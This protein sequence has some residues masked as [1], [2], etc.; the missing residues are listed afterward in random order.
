[1]VRPDLLGIVS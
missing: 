1:M